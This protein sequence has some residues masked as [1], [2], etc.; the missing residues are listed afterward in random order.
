M[1]MGAYPG[2]GVG[3][4]VSGMNMGQHGGAQVPP[5]FELRQATVERTNKRLEKYR[6]NSENKHERHE[7]CRNDQLERDLKETEKY[8][9]KVSEQKQRKKSTRE[10]KDEKLGPG[11]LSKSAELSI[12]TQIS[13]NIKSSQEKMAKKSKSKA[14]HLSIGF[15][16]GAAFADIDP[17]NMPLDDIS[18]VELEKL[19]PSDGYPGHPPAGIKQE[20]QSDSPLYHNMQPS[21]GPAFPGQNFYNQA[22]YHH[23]M[24]GMLPANQMSRYPPVSAAPI[25]G[26]FTPAGGTWGGQPAHMIPPQTGSPGTGYQY[27][28]SSSEF[29]PY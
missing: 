9:L 1:D 28:Q 21:S 13:K 23:Q 25:H 11:G 15:D 14:S 7:E 24:S 27:S 18:S 16:D 29:H 3:P 12:M 10:K 26:G 8:L 5:S 19:L 22:F 17:S 20:G 4:P 2:P 6:K